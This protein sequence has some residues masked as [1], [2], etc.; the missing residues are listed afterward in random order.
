MRYR[1]RLNSS[2]PQNPE[3]PP[4]CFDGATN[5]DL[6]TQDFFTTTLPEHCKHVRPFRPHAES[7]YRV[8]VRFHLPGL[9]G[10]ERLAHTT[11]AAATV[12]RASPEPGSPEARLDVAS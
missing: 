8:S 4:E 2:A 5:V 12:T 3:W 7:W 1:G 6:A 10:N 9:P 11:R